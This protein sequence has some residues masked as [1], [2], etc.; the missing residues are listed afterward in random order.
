MNCHDFVCFMC[1]KN[2]INNKNNF[3]PISYFIIFGLG[4]GGGGGGGSQGNDEDLLI[5][6]VVISTRKPKSLK[7][8]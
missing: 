7:I 6:F 2:V 1:C 3:K 8:D 5:H 4:G